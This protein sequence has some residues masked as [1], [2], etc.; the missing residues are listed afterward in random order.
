MNF[1]TKHMRQDV[2]RTYYKSCK[3]EILKQKKYDDLA[4]LL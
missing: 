3:F 2:K 4:L 1:E